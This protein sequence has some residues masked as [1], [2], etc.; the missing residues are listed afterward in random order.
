MN[1]EQHDVAR[2]AAS[3]EVHL[4]GALP[5]KLRAAFPDATASPAPAQTVLVR[6]VQHNSELDVLLDQLLFMGLVLDE[7]HERAATPA[8]PVD[9]TATF[10]RRSVQR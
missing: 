6:E 2:A 3:Y 10:S 7:V 1:P 4:S 5:P 8:L 9:A